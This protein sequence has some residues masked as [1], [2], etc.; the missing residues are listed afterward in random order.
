[1]VFSVA[2]QGLKPPSRGF[3][4]GQNFKKGNS[5]KTWVG[6]KKEGA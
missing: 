5:K 6:S 4:S 2:L 1:M 3:F